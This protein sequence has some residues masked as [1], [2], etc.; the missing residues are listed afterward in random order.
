M[1]GILIKIF[2]YNHRLKWYNDIKI[3]EIDMD[4]SIRNP[5]YPTIE[6]KTNFN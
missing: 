3:K 5:N 2:D 4:N 6:L 1:T